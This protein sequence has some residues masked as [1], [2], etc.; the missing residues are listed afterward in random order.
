VVTVIVLPFHPF[1]CTAKILDRPR[2]VKTDGAVKNVNAELLAGL[3]LETFA[4]FF[5]DYDLKLG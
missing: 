2:A 4:D 5:G 1:C 3:K